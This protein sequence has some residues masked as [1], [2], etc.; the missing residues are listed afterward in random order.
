MRSL[1]YTLSATFKIY[2][3]GSIRGGRQD[4]QLY[5]RI[6]EM[7]GKHGTV[8]TEMV[9][10]RGLTASGS[11][12]PETSIYEKDM[13]WLTEADA[14]VAEVTAPSLGVGYELAKAEDMGKPVLCLYRES[15]E[16]KLSAMI[17]GNPV[18]KIHTYAESND[19]GP[20]FD[21]FFTGQ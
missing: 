1:I 9:G 8:L 5:G 12:G 2:F 11:D 16:R 19:L 18:F 13:A 21:T 14:V 3:S 20:V 15:P 7:L 10:D 4:V 6:I 17:A